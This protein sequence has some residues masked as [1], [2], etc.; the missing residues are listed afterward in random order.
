V[1]CFTAA[2]LVAQASPLELI[3]DDALGFAVIKDLGEA[4][5]RLGKVAAKMQ[6][7]LGDV[8]TMVKG[9]LGV[10]DGLD[11]KGGLAIALASGGEGR[12]WEDSMLVAIV[13]ASDY[14]A[15]VAGWEPED[16]EA[17]ITGVTVMGM[18]ML[19]AHKGSFAVL[20]YGED[21]EKLEKFL[22]ATKNVT[23]TIE[24][25]K[26]WMADKQLALVVTPA[27]KKLLL[28]T[29]AA[30]IPASE[31]LKKDAENSDVEGAPQALALANVGEMFSGLKELLGA[32]NEQLTQLA[33]GLHIDDN[34]ALRLAVRA[35]F[36]RDGKLAAWSKELKA[37]SEGL[38]AGVPAGNYALAYGGV[39]AHFSP[40]MQA[41]LD[42]FTEM[43]MQMVGMDEAARKQVAEITAKLQ[44]GKRFT[45]GVM[46]LMRPGDSLF[47][48]AL[49][50]EHV[51]NADKQL[52]LTR[53]M[54]KLMASAQK[55]PKTGEPL[56]EY[57]EVKV[58]ELAALELV[59]SLGELAEAA[60]GEGDGAAGAQLQGL[61]GKLFG[62]DGKI[63]MY[64]AKGNDKTLVSAYGKEQLMR[65][66]E[67]V[68]AGGAGLEAD[69]DI[70][71]TTAM[72]PEG[73]QWV[74]YVSPQG[75]VQWIGVFV[76][77][78]F[79]GQTK[80]P[81]FP[82]T[83]PIGLAAKVTPTGLDAELVLPEK[84]VAGIGQYIFT[85][86]QMFQGGGAPLP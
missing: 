25:L 84:V 1:W 65:G 74:A 3:P 19:A 45:G 64:V 76:E 14:K 7:P 82:A 12:A 32:A 36:T 16:A 53:E 13:P 44:A 29:I 51:E 85:I 50:V 41:V 80:L 38:L 42:K 54:F 86:G 49:T 11:E 37:P 30:A 6:L 47:S 4:N 68:R 18:K 23:A 2:T 58:G 62:A 72:L 59:T 22:G 71:K 61:F 15:L 79:G 24:P 56:Y 43:G 81:P 52:G 8:L 31:Q 40:E 46:G 17:A 34:A 63:H 39:S 21:K 57:N 67:H 28:E 69:A 27:G 55:N 33:I 75:L 70:A 20:G 9:L 35:L 73:A 83:E 60:Q 77:A 78:M 66:V 5:D 10:Q 26:A 48:T